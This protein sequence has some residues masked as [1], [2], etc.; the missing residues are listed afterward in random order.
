L[1]RDGFFKDEAAADAA[2]DALKAWDKIDDDVK[3]SAIGVL[4]LD[5]K[6]KVKTQK[7]GSRSITKGAGIGLLLVL[8][9]PGL[10]VPT[11]IAGGVVG[12]LRHKGLGISAEDRGRI[13][14]NLTNG[15]AAVAVLARTD[16][17][18]LVAAKLTELGGV[19]ESHEIAPEVEAEVVAAAPEVEA[20]ILAAPE[21]EAAT[22]A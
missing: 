8:L 19:T 3:L 2:V 22:E 5:E 7:L 17:A 20:E 18:A 1:L 12:A 15:Q 11:I 21:G 6:G 13:G 10:V 14:T 4:T 16:E 9:V